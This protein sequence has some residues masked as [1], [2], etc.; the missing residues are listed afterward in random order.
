MEFWACLERPAEIASSTHESFNN[1]YQ[2]P[3]CGPGEARRPEK[4]RSSRSASSPAYELNSQD[5]QFT[6]LP[7]E[8]SESSGDD[9]PLGSLIGSTR[10]RRAYSRAGV[11]AACTPATP[12]P[13]LFERKVYAYPDSFVWPCVVLLTLACEPPAHTHTSPAS[14]SPRPRSPSSPRT[15]ALGWLTLFVRQAPMSTGSDND[16]LAQRADEEIAEQVRSE[17]MSESESENV[18]E[19]LECEAEIESETVMVAAGR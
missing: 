17:G 11:A 16:F 12:A 1:T 2:G 9:Q 19:R 15:G 18:D 13:V 14:R 7:P 8:E 3:T 6:S 10:A 4:T 5:H